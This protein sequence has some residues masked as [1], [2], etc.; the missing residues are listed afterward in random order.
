MSDG[1]GSFFDMGGYGAFVWPAYALVAALL[2]WLLVNRIGR[3]KRRES[4]LARLEQARESERP[5]A[6]SAP[7]SSAKERA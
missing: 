6:K 5:P 7:I 1:L 3:L 4:E 2:V